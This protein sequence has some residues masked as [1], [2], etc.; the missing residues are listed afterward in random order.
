[1]EGPCLSLKL[2]GWKYGMSIHDSRATAGGIFDPE[3]LPRVVSI[4]GGREP[5]RR[6]AGSFKADGFGPRLPADG[7][8]QQEVHG[9]DAVANRRT[10]DDVRR[11]DEPVASGPDASTRAPLVRGFHDRRGMI[12]LRGFCLKTTA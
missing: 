3:T 4:C 9:Q 12:C 5:G 2:I 7:P 6:Q 8:D 1:M 10:E 11:H